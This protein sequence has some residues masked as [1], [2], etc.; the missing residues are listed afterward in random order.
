MEGS[1]ASCPKVIKNGDAFVLELTLVLYANCIG[2]M[3]VGQSMVVLST[4]D[5]KYLA[6]VLLIN[7]AELFDCGW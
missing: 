3:Y 5:D 6:M 1:L 7:S 2:A 4:K